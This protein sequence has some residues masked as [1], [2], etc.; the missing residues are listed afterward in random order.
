MDSG[1]LF[2]AVHS[3]PTAEVSSGKGVMPPVP[4]WFNDLPEHLR[5]DVSKVGPLEDLRNRYGFSHEIFVM[6]ISVGEASTRRVQHF[7]FRQLRAQMPNV[8]EKELWKAVLVS[9][10]KTTLDVGMAFGIKPMEEEDIAEIVERAKTFEDVC[11]AIIE[12]ERPQRT[13][14]MSGI[15]REIDALL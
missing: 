10:A 1:N 8:P 15:Q 14:D 11:E 12:H 9:R 6:A 4:K 7:M 3:P 13:I 2:S 5:P